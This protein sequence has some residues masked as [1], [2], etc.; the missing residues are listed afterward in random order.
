[1]C[2]C[3]NIVAVHWKRTAAGIIV[4]QIWD[5]GAEPISHNA[6]RTFAIANPR[7]GQAVLP[8]VPSAQWVANRYAPVTDAIMNDPVIA[9]A[10]VIR[11]ATGMDG[12]HLARPRAAN[13]TAWMCQQR[14]S[15]SLFQP[16]PR[17]QL[18]I[19]GADL[20]AILVN[21]PVGDPPLEDLV[22]DFGAVL[23]V[24]NSTVAWAT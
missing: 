4:E 19:A 10:G 22:L 5:F 20:A 6:K 1:M 24:I 18:N 7:P 13:A 11:N 23:H 16:G 12:Q 3:F 9:S 15:V 14:R 17:P 2:P 21:V 8:A